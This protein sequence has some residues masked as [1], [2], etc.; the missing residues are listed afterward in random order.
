[1][2]CQFQ[3]YIHVKNVD[4]KFICVLMWSFDFF[5]VLYFENFLEL[6]YII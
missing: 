2:V 4:F 5:I 3:N 6:P 1:M